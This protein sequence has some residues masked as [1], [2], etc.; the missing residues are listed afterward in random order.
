MNLYLVRHTKTNCPDGTC[1]GQL[2]VDVLPSFDEEKENVILQLEDIHFN[3]VYT[4]P[5]KR[6]M[7]LAKAIHTQF[8][9]AIVID[10]RLME[11]NFG[12]WEGGK[13]NEISSTPEAIQWFGDFL[14][15]SCPG[16]ESY[17]ELLNRVRCFLSD[18]SKNHTDENIVIVT[19]AGVIRAIHAIVNQKDAWEVFSLPVEYGQIVVLSDIETLNSNY[20]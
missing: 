6:C 9:P 15:T 19:H 14:N 16:G 3:T 7:L 8:D 18:L 17:Q 5:L 10:K 20:Y 4:S 1:Y 2:D 11:L 12:E 13:W